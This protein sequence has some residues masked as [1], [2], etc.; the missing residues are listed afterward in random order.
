[1]LFVDGFDVGDFALKWVNFDPSQTTIS[2]VTPFAHGRSIKVESEDYAQLLKRGIAASAMAIAGVNFRYTADSIF[3]ADGSKVGVISL[4]SDG[5]STKHLWLAVDYNGT[6]RLH[7]GSTVIASGPAGQIVAGVYYFFEI[8]ATIADSGGTAV[9]RVNEAEIINFTGDTRNGG[10]STNIDMVGLH[11]VAFNTACPDSYYDDFY[12]CDASGSVNNDFLGIGR[13]QTL[14]PD[15]AGADN[16][17]TPVGSGSNYENVNDVPWSST[18]YN[19][20]TTAGD[21]DLYTLDDLASATAEV[22]GIQTVLIAQSSDAAAGVKAA[23]RSGGTVYYDADVVLNGTPSDVS[24]VVREDDPA[25]SA[26]WTVSGVNA[27]EAGM[28]VTS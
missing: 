25:T 22:A 1:M 2:T 16:D 27:L 12:V 23:L 18:D 7:R 24:I 6:V 21:R 20:S 4:Y 10:S 14:L 17:L 28:E 8:K 26:P 15:G 9:V 19:Y 11:D 5:G 3:T 13:V